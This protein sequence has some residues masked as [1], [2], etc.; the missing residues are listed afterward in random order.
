[1]NVIGKDHGRLASSTISSEC[2]WEG[3]WAT[4]LKYHIKSKH[5]CEKPYHC[6][7]CDYQTSA[8]GCMKIHMMGHAGEKPFKCDL[9][10]CRFVSSGHLKMHM[11]RGIHNQKGD[12]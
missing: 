6:E 7:D 11:K 5:T 4:S 12:I 10:D 8:L 9:C 1:M 2:D 3:S